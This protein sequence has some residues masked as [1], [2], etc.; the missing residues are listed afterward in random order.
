MSEKRVV[1]KHMSC[2]K[3]EKLAQVEVISSMLLNTGCAE[4]MLNVARQMIM[5]KK[6]VVRQT[7]LAQKFEQQAH[8]E[9]QISMVALIIQTMRSTYAKMVRLVRER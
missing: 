7:L 6:D 2:R 1:T 8:I 9:Q 5:C 3:N 4:H